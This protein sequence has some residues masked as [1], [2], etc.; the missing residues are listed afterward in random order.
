MV[1]WLIQRPSFIGNIDNAGKN[2][3]FDG[4]D[5]S[6]INGALIVF[7]YI[8]SGGNYTSPNTR[9][10][11]IKDYEEQDSD[12]SQITPTCCRGRQIDPRSH[13]LH[14]RYNNIIIRL[15]RFFR[16]FGFDYSALSDLGE[17]FWDLFSF[18]SSI[19]ELLL[20]QV[21]KSYCKR[22][23]WKFTIEMCSKTVKH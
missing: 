2:G 19:V 4:G 6:F 20:L 21:Y 8:G 7:S 13:E 5:R 1:E 3:N 15:P 14:S 12:K 18:S 9:D 10:P 22:S 16:R 23:I 11:A 17:L